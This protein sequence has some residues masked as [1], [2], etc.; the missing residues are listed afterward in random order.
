MRKKASLFWGLALGL[1]IIDFF[2][3]RWVVATIAPLITG[4]Y[5]FGGIGVFQNWFGVSFALVHE[6]NRGAILGI[7]SNYPYL[8][9]VFRIAF[10]L[11]LIYF[12]FSKKPRLIEVVGLALIVGGALGNIVDVFLYGHVIDMFKLVFG[13]FHYPVFNI[14]DSG[15]TVGAAF[16]ILGYLKK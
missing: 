3:K 6:V 15:I 10:V 2:V 12:A 1:F 14:A 9:V 7:F 8:L 13:S 11:Y 5:P 4:T 16:Y